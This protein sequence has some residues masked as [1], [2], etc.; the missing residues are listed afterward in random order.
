MIMRYLTLV[1]AHLLA[2]YPLQGPF[3]AE[4]KGRNPLTLVSHAGI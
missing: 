4:T 3:L 2:D 1:F